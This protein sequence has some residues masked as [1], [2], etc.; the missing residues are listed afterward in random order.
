MVDVKFCEGLPQVRSLLALF[1]INLHNSD[2]K[3]CILGMEMTYF[4]F[5]YYF[6]ITRVLHMAPGLRSAV[7][8]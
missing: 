8:R 4:E 7:P 3:I 6:N 1:M 5:G 2:C